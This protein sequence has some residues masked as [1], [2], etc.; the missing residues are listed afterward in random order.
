MPETTQIRYDLRELTALML[1]D[2]DIKSGLWMIQATFT[3]GVSNLLSN[4]AGGPSGPGIFGVLGGMGLQKTDERNPLS[5]DAA[6]LWKK[7]APKS[8]QPAGNR[9]KG[10]AR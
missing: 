6:E 9:Q 1:R 7:K 10:K 3:L 5:V 2:Q 4:S 8:R